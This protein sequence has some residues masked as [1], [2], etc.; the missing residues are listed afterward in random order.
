MGSSSTGSPKWS[1]TSSGTAP[2]F[3]LATAKPSNTDCASAIVYACDAAFLYYLCRPLVHSTTC[4]QFSGVLQHPKKGRRDQK[5]AYNSNWRSVTRPL[6]LS[7]MAVTVVGRRA[8]GQ[9][10]SNLSKFGV[11]SVWARKHNTNQTRST[12]VRPSNIHQ[13]TRIRLTHAP[14]F[15]GLAVQVATSPLCCSRKGRGAAL[16][17]RMVLTG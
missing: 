13:P 5:Q 4:T 3:T 14:L 6:W 1:I 16:S 7:T 17:M 12:N 11:M 8:L 15:K 10:P 2:S 9:K